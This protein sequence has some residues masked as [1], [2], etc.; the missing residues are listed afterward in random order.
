[1]PLPDRNALGAS[2]ERLLEHD[3]PIDDAQDHGGSIAVYLHDPDGN[4]IELS[5]DR[6]LKRWF[7]AGATRS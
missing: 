2:L 3:H 4:G 5:Y 6:P 7:D 1:M